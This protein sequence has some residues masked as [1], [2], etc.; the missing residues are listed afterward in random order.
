MPLL[1][2]STVGTSLLTNG[3]SRD[4]A[5]VLT[6]HANHSEA[7]LPREVRELVNRRADAARQ[8]LTTP[9]AVRKASAELNG[10]LTFYEEQKTSPGS[11]DIH[12]L[13][14]T[15]TCQG[16]RTAALITDFLLRS[17]INDV[18]AW[19]PAGLSTRDTRSFS[20]GMRRLL[21][22]IEML[23]PAVHRTNG[24]RVIFNLVGGFKSLQGYLNTV[25]MFHADEIIYI[26][27][28][29]DS[30]LLRIP[31]LPV[32]LDDTLFRNHAR[33]LSLLEAADS[34]DVPGPVLQGSL[35]KLPELMIY[36]IDGRAMLSEWGLLAWQQ[37][38]DVLLAES[39][40]PLPRLQFTDRFRRE[41]QAWPEAKA[42]V[43]L[44]ERLARASVLLDQSGGDTS[45]LKR[46]SQL[47]YDNFSGALAAL[48][49]FRA[50]AS[51]GG[52][53]RVS[54]EALPNGQGLLLRRF[55]AHDDINV[56]P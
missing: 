1:M 36:D 17:G 16:R 19:H 21:R 38:K 50:S 22:D 56:N 40:I 26:F 46:D 8:A 31:R 3:A 53:L 39:L 24:Y 41:F 9:A 54:C 34:L 37:A 12:L 7:E 10:I 6:R 51:G 5:L 28:G 45:V 20:D 48:G 11:R 55:G 4:E 14:A 42:R 30:K 49:H 47:Q 43:R 44:Q 29:E 15:D 33:E 23:D 32:R 52:S 35:A 25:A 13:V 2:L 27:E 18:R